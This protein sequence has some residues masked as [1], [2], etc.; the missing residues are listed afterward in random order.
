M[1]SSASAS[2]LNTTGDQGAEI[3]G[4]LAAL[5]TVQ[6]WADSRCPCEN[7]QPNPCPLCGAS[8]ENLEPCKSAEK[9]LPKS[10]REAIRTAL[11]K[12]TP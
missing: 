12:A 9:T 8:V 4:L 1:T 7:E 3:A 11:A 5:R 10:V 6:R 2:G